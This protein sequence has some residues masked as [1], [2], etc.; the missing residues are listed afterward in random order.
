VKKKT[1]NAFGSNQ[2]VFEAFLI[3]HTSSVSGEGMSKPTFPFYNTTAEQIQLCKI[4][5]IILKPASLCLS[6]NN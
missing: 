3:S 4:K 2:I 5:K 1:K 6:E